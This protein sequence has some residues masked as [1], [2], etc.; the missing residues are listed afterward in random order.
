MPTPRPRKSRKTP[1]AA[2]AARL[3]WDDLRLVL[4]VARQGR[5]GDAAASLGLDP[6][7]VGRRLAAL[8]QRLGTTLF[9]RGSRG[10]VPTPAVRALLP[11]AEAMEAAADGAERKLNAGIGPIAGPVTLAAS[12]AFSMYFLFD[13]L[14]AVRA[15]WP[16]VALSLVA[17]HGLANLARREADIALRFVRPVQQDLHA[18]RL[19]SVRWSLYGSPG[20]LRHRPPP[21]PA[22][23]LPGHRLVRWGG[24][25]LRPKVD[26]WLAAHANAA[27]T[28]LTVT[29]LHLI[30]EAA[31]RGVG[32]AVMPGAM[33]IGRGGLE[34]VIDHAIDETDLW[35]VVHRD[36]RRVPRIRA[37]ADALAAR[38]DAARTR[39]R[40]L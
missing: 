39:L 9:E 24:P 16:E 28:A 36:S 17:A 35:L 7:N 2:P 11:E 26:E 5:L 18:R 21:D 3:D 23:G 10:L 33:A 1:R 40:A 27:E 38:I 6:S 31:A 13:E 4:H 29:Q 22:H 20:Y 8:D 34:R 19:A 14:A 12:E 37:V 32:L 25:P 15:E 30:I